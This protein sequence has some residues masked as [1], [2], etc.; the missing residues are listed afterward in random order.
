MFSQNIP[1]S[2]DNILEYL[3]T[4]FTNWTSGNEKINSFIQ[5][6]QLKISHYDDNDMVLE[7]IPYN[8][9][10]EIKETG[11][12]G[13]ITV[14]SAIW[15]D[16]PLYKK[17]NHSGYIRDSNKKVALKCLYNS[18]ESIDSLINEAKKYPTKY[19]AFQ[20]LYGITQNPDTGDY[21]LVQNYT[22][23]WISGNE[24]IDDFIQERQLKIN[25]Y[26]YYKDIVLEW[27]PYNQFNEIKETSNNG[28][29]TVYSAIWKDGP[30]YK[31]FGF[32]DY[33]RD[34]NNKVALKCF[35]NSQE[36]IYS[37][38]IETEQY[39][40][41]YEAFQVLH[42]ISQNP[43]TGDYILVQNN[44]ISL[45]NW[46]SG[47][48]KIDYF[49][50]ERQLKI[51]N[52]NNIVL[53]YIPYN[54]FNE[55]KE[56]GKN[57]LITVYSAIWKDGPICKE[58]NRWS[59]YTR[60]SNKKIALKCFHN[61][62]GSIDTLINEAKKYS[63]NTNNK[64][65]LYGISQNPD[66]GDY[67]LVQNNFIN[68]VNWVS[69]NE[70]IDYFI[71]ESYNYI[72]LEWIPY[73]QFYEIKK[74]GK[75]G[76]ITVYSAIWKDGPLYKNYSS[77]DYTRDS[78][79][80][81]ALKCLHNT[82]ES[83]DLLINEAKKHLTKYKKSQVLYGISRNPDTEDYIFIL[84]WTSGNEKIDDF[85]Q[86]R[87]LKIIDDDDIGNIMLEWIPYNQFN[88]IKE[89]G[90]NGLITVYSATW[91]DGPL[92]KKNSLNNYTRD[93]NK[94]VALKCLHNS[95]VSIDFLINK[96]GKYLTKYRESQVLYGIS[97][98]PDTEDYILVFNWS[99]GNEIIDDF[100]Q[101]RQLKINDNNDVVFKWISYSQFNDIKEIGKGG[102]STVYSAIWKD[103]PLD[104][105]VHNRNGVIALKCL[106]S[107]Q[108]ITDKFLNEVKEYSINKS[109]NILNIYGI[110]QNPNTKEYIMVLQY[111][112]EGNFN[113]WMNKN[114][115]Y[116]NWKDKLS[117]LLNIIN[118]LK[119][120]H[121]KNLVHRDFHTGNILFLNFIDNFN[122]CVSI[123]DMGLCGE[124]GNIDETKIYGVMPYV[125]P[126][127]LR[128]N[129][130]TQAADIYSFGMVM[131]F[132]ATGRQPFG[133]RAH[134]YD[135][136]LDIC[137]GIGPEISEPEAPRCYIDLMKKCWDLDKNNRPDV[138]GLDK[139]IT[140]FLV[141]YTMD[142]AILGEIKIQFEEAEEYRKAN[143]S[144]TENYQIVTH[145]QA[146][147]TSRLL[148]PITKDLPKNDDGYNSQCLDD[149]ALPISFK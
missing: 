52:Y 122:N 135:L 93:S 6:M 113:H 120:I 9:F 103:A 26:D 100:I 53:E 12:H 67:I 78:N 16:G 91:K 8:Q 81:V 59:N 70:K 132:V 56:T 33:T 54:Q 18:Q 22:A 23:N 89:T 30:L 24:K 96:A 77:E 133:N 95:Q 115:K 86:E 145:P 127:V 65:F 42:G 43:V 47:N 38:K 17:Y 79:K 94:D 39:P 40:T 147:Y 138:F 85:I 101:E 32:E 15:R 142:L 136:A 111:A 106:H 21:I 119:E 87:P 62:Q 20:V 130:Y 110:S 134:D 60:D 90:K 126:E 44:F 118:G 31:N 64:V 19:K 98:N 50:K 143:I 125:A 74:T 129:H 57:G 69:G 66:T 45:V 14:Y 149:C 82:Q 51:D 128:G 131:Y 11:K 117:A 35:H 75:S 34:S 46:I 137:K 58:Y 116:F 139:E 114:Y 68:L 104:K 55:I 49:I 76:L 37:L 84:T 99:S 1:L 29:I 25:D 124:V 102:F 3:E 92:Y 123:S 80:K 72:V 109:S 7:W 28:L 141:S 71:Q 63:I 105:K 108:N 112:K 121:Q 61:T 5:E 83:I 48:E 27:I 36:F 41:N 144:S 140:S 10:N 148:N 107:S 2:K 73:N 88:E 4:N 146:I 97:Q 13:L